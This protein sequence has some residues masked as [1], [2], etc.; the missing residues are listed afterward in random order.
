VYDTFFH[1]QKCKTGHESLGNVNGTL[2]PGFLK[3]PENNDVFFTHINYYTMKEALRQLLFYNKDLNKFKFVETGCS[4]HGTKSTLL[5]DKFVNFYDGSVSSV[6][7]NERAVNNTNSLISNKSKVFHSNSLDYLP[8]VECLIDFLYMDSGDVD[9]LNP[10]PSAMHH[11]EE[12]NR[13]KHLL[14]KN[15]IILIDDTPVSPEW[16]DDG[17]NNP[18]Y[19]TLKRQFNPKIAGKGSL[20]NLELEKMG[21]TKILH[22]YQTLWRL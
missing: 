11:L 8:K 7:L 22:Q 6:D 12:F 18:I 14:H 16:L 17:Q 13:V 19:S 5:W 1:K 21:A 10:L 15:S 3:T 2:I 4:A 20:V 9:F